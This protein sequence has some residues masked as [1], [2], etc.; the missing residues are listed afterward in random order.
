MLTWIWLINNLFS[1]QILQINFIVL[2]M[3]IY[4]KIFLKQHSGL[5]SLKRYLY[6][7]ENYLNISS[8]VCLSFSP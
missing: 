5:S 3:E 6:Y 8:T 4:L 7:Y 2:K 1:P